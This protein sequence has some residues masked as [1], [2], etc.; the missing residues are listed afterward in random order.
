MSTVRQSKYFTRD[1]L[2]DYLNEHRREYPEKGDYRIEL[3]HFIV[4]R[5]P[6]NIPH[7]DHDKVVILAGE[8]WP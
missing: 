8:P 2:A 6:E 3:R 7:D 5:P 1:S 4:A